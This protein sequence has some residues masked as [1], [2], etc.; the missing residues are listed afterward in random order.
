MKQFDLETIIKYFAFEGVFNSVEP[1]GNGH[2]NDSFVVYFSNGDGE[3]HQY[4]L[5]RINHLVFTKPLEAMHNIEKIT[6]HLREKIKVQGGDVNRET[7]NLI[8]THA[9]QNH[10]IDASGNYWRAYIFINDAKTYDV[11]ESNMHLYNAGKAVGLFQKQLADF[12]VNELYETIAGFH[13]TQKRYDVFLQA[14]QTN[15]MNRAHL[16]TKEIAFLID[17]VSDMDTIVTLLDNGRLP[18]RVTHNDTKFNNIMIDTHTGDGICVIDLDT[19]MPGSA[20]YDFGD[21]IR[22]GTNTGLE[23]EKDLSKVSF[24]IQL[25]AHFTKGYLESASDLLTE[26]EISMLPFSAKLITMEIGMRFLTDFLCGDIYFKTQYEDHNL[27]RA[28]TQLK[29]VSDMENQMDQMEAIVQKYTI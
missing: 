22:S 14:V 17:R 5:Q 2:I 18:T 24:D 10:H 16:A 1:C 20:L 26:L 11:V 21:S 28:R 19:V 7:L 23:D 25:F 4:F 29:L 27:S 9:H 12:P 8:L 15:C 6:Q 13:H 3:M